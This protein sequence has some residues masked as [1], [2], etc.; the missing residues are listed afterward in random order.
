MHIL[1]STGGGQV[2]TLETRIEGTHQ[3]QRVGGGTSQDMEISQASGG[4]SPTAKG[5]GRDM[6]GH[7]KKASNGGKSQDRTL[8]C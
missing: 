4:H 3:L 8:T 2:S 6:L 5:K 1:A 7:P